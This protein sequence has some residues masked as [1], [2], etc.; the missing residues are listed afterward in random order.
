MER[1]FGESSLAV[2]ATTVKSAMGAA[3]ESASVMPS[4]IASAVRRSI[5]MRRTRSIERPIDPCVY[6]W[7][8]NSQRLPFAQAL[9][10]LADPMTTAAIRMPK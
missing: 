1:K 6:L 8:I 3:I 10:N 2:V 9:A 7:K 5:V 4:G